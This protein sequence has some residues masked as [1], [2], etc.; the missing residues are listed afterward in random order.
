MSTGDWY[1]HS[2]NQLV[3]FNRGVNTKSHTAGS[4]AQSGPSG[5]TEAKRESKPDNLGVFTPFFLPF[6]PFLPLFLSVCLFVFQSVSL[7]LLLGCLQEG[8][9]RLM[10][11]TLA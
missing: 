11:L 3:I 5:E 10:W 4:L 8:C 1:C 7:M 6:L 9:W 2:I